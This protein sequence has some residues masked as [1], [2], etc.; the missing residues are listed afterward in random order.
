MIVS[1]WIH[2]EGS[3]G[4]CTISN[5]DAALR[6]NQRSEK[7]IQVVDQP[8][9]IFGTDN[10]RRSTSHQWTILPAV[11]MMLFGRPMDV[12]WTFFK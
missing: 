4:S 3:I 6:F 1:N 5:F 2:S 11:D 7:W 10:R 8:S 9:S 12:Q